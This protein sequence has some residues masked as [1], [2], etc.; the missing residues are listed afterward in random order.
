MFTIS[1]S[2]SL[3]FTFLTIISIGCLIGLIASSAYFLTRPLISAPDIHSCETISTSNSQLTTYLR[4]VCT[5]NLSRPESL[6]TDLVKIEN[7]LNSKANITVTFDPSVRTRDIVEGSFETL[8]Q[9]LFSDYPSDAALPIRAAISIFPSRA[10]VDTATNQANNDIKAPLPYFILKPEVRQRTTLYAMS[11]P[12]VLPPAQQNT[13][14]IEAIDDSADVQESIEVPRNA[15]FLQSSLLLAGTVLTV[16][17]SKLLHA[18]KL[19]SETTDLLPS[20]DAVTSPMWGA[21]IHGGL[22][23]SKEVLAIVRPC[24][25]TRFNLRLSWL[26]YRYGLPIDEEAPSCAQ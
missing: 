3:K 4:N 1:Q 25:E 9:Q 14:A 6:T 21:H 18:L 16:L 26:S 2:M 17:P 10:L 24:N 20:M 5:Q 23:M 8:E 7:Y 22:D 12:P 11:S 15:T 19:R 13:T